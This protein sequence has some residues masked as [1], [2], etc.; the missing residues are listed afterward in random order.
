MQQTW[1]DLLFAHYPIYM[2]RLRSLVPEALTIDTFN[3]VGWIGIVPFLLQKVEGGT[4]DPRHGNFS[5]AKCKN[6]CHSRWQARC[7]FHKHGRY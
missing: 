3:G 6:V 2:E 7:V 4:S 1:N 5:R